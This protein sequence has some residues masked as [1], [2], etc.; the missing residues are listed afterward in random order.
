MP[1]K[2]DGIALRNASAGLGGRISRAS[3][4]RRSIASGYVSSVQS[5]ASGKITTATV[6]VAGSG[7]VRAQ[8]PWGANVYT[9]MGVQIE[10]Y[11]SPSNASWAIAGSSYLPTGT[12]GGVITNQ[13]GNIIALFDS[14]W[15]KDDGYVMVGGSED[16]DGNPVGSRVLLTEVG[17]F[18]YDS[19]DANNLAIYVRDVGDQHLAGDMVL[20]YQ[21]GGRIEL[22]AQGRKFGIWNANEIIVS[23]DPATG[24]RIT[25]ALWVGDEAGPQVGVGRLADD[26]FIVARNA[27]TG[28]MGEIGNEPVFLVS[29]KPDRVTVH[30]GDPD[31]SDSYIFYDSL[32]QRLD[33]DADIVARSLTINGGSIVTENGYIQTQAPGT[34]AHI[35]ITNR[36]MEGIGTGGDRTFLLAGAAVTLPNNPSNL[37]LGTH[38]WLGGEG[39]WGDLLSRHFRIERGINARI[40]LFNG[41]TPTVYSTY[42]GDTIVDGTVYARNREV[43][44]GRAGRGVEIATVVYSDAH[45]TEEIEVGSS[46]P[47][48][49]L[50]YV[51][52][53]TYNPVAGVSGWVDVPDGTHT[54]ANLQVKVSDKRAAP[55]DWARVRVL[56]NAPVDGEAI[57]YLQAAGDNGNSAHMAQFFLESNRY[58]D[59]NRNFSLAWLDTN[60]T[61]FSKSTAQPTQTTGSLAE[62]LLTYADGWSPNGEGVSE[63]LFF[64][65]NTRWVPIAVASGSTRYESNNIDLLDYALR[66]VGNLEL[67]NASTQAADFN[68]GAFSV[69]RINT[70]SAA[71]TATL[72][73]L[74]TISDNDHRIYVFIKMNSG[75]NTLTLDGYSTETINGAATQ[76][77]SGQYSVRILVST[78]GGWFIIGSVGT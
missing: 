31:R 75:G 25:G 20:G 32:A 21:D 49:L 38:D 15:V 4:P 16:P 19:Y 2:L 14:I 22:S 5:D 64:R 45:D 6:Q 41:E 7:S 39:Y 34:Q 78:D 65:I 74:S 8:V 12:T 57:V 18:G 72:P 66:G 44:L 46:A 62:G 11:G 70:S 69:Y 28:T 60:A 24:N 10:N 71:V 52:S 55:A 56:A 36:Y 76:T 27:G 54:R 48:E 30:V 33:V 63:G 42:T 37:A 9:G 35:K 67:S 17:V 51:E 23:F 73:Q 58:G 50:T 47:E 26:A 68:V 43:V 3:Q 29:A 13:N 61:R 1:K 59:N 40:G 53:G 77:F